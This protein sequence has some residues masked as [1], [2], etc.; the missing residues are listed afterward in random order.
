MSAGAA[1]VRE[2]VPTSSA[3]APGSPD[4]LPNAFRVFLEHASPRFLVPTSL[5]AIATRLTLG[6]WSPWDAAVVAGIFLVWPLQE[7]MIHV[8]ILHFRPLRLAGWTLDFAVPR[9]HRAHHR[10]PWNLELLF[11]P[12]QG[13]FTGI[14]LLL[15]LS[16][17]LLPTVEMAATA[18]AFYLLMT[19]RY[20]WIHFLVH[21]RY[22]PRSAWYRRLWRN[23]RLHHCKN[24]RYWYG[25]TM[26]GGDR[27]LRTAPAVDA[28]VTS[29]TCRSLGIE[30]GPDFGTS[31]GKIAV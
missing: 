12:I 2:A 16:L 8:F 29:A 27:V 28:V 17:G 11:I 19:L 30:V 1:L 31:A 14:P 20:E 13:Y 23:H 21:T 26:L 7:W 22:R 3:D 9:K 25:V 4:T 18:V 24:E 15:A 10:N 5:V 6:D